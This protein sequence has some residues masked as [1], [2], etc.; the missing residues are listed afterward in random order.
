MKF[1]TGYR[2]PRP[3]L[4]GIESGN[5][6]PAERPS[7]RMSKLYREK[8]SGNAMKGIFGQDN[9]AWDTEKQEGVFAGQSVFDAEAGGA[10]QQVF[11]G[12]QALPAFG[13]PSTA[14]PAQQQAAQQQADDEVPYPLAGSFAACDAC[15]Q[16][17]QRYYH[18]A[19]CQEDTGL[20]DLC[21]ECCAAVYLKQGTPAALAKMRLPDH[22]THVYETHQ[23]VH[24]VPP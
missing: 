16:V 5:K 12:Q 6:L 22:P 24:I 19:D 8:E 14:G 23:M 17:V 7:V 4:A 11:G 15:G 10:E 20:F 13:G 9:L 1:N 21:T 18:C 2:S 3:A